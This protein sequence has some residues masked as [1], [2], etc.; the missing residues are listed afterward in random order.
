MM[1]NTTNSYQ[2]IDLTPA[3]RAFL[4]SLN[5]PRP[6]RVMYGLL[7]VDVTRIRQ[8][9]A[10]HK[11]QSGETLSFTGYLAYCLAYAVSE[12]KEVQAYRKGRRQYVLFD[13]VDVGLMVEKQVGDQ[14]ELS[15]YVVRRANHKTYLELHQELRQAQSPQVPV[16]NAIPG[17][18]RRTMLLPVPLPQLF[19]AFL[20]MLIRGNPAMLVT[21]QGTVGVTA[22]GMF[23][24]GHSGWGISATRH[25]LDLVV[26]ST[27]WKPAV[28]EGRIEPRELLHLTVV[29][30]HEVVDGAPAA[31]FTRRLVEMIES[32]FGLSDTQPTSAL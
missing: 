21:M 26:G 22:V 30:D 4:T 8:V 27:A 17:W 31:R 1:N 20:S 12:N 23:G 5:L 14:R 16:G 13:D 6:R 9:I 11:A 10:Q 32:G 25:S 7:E 2:V 28:I 18:F 3:R 15:G 19:I 24:K 29:F